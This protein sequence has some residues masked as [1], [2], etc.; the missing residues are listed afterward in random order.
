MRGGLRAG[1]GRKRGPGSVMR[2]VPLPVLAQVDAVLDAYRN[3]SETGI[4]LPSH[5][6]ELPNCGPDDAG[7]NSVPEIE[8]AGDDETAIK[9]PVPVAVNLDLE[10]KRVFAPS[11][12]QSLDLKNVLDDLHKLP[13]PVLKQLRKEYGTLRNAVLDGV[14][15]HGKTVVR[16]TPTHV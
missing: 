6:G 13:N 14:R 11:L 2:R 7:L 8:L 1:A 10:P 4:N 15:R 16:V 3:K 9:Q 12:Q 5:V